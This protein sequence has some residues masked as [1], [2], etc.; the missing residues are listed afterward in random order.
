MLWSDTSHA[1]IKYFALLMTLS[2]ALQILW[3]H[4]RNFFQQMWK[5]KI[6]GYSY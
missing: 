3:L 5:L 2:P 6:F 1:G 4:S